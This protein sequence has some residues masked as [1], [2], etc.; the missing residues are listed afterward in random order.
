VRYRGNRFGFRRFF[1]REE[2]RAFNLSV[3]EALKQ[4]GDEAAQAIMD[5]MKQMVDKAV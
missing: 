4:H 3:R 5:E 1:E 2:R